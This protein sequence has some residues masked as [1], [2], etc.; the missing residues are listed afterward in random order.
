MF[1]R[2]RVFLLL[3]LPYSSFRL[4]NY[5]I[6]V[7]QWKVP[8]WNHRYINIWLFSIDMQIE[9]S[10]PNL[11]LYL[12]LCTLYVYWVC[13]GGNAW[14]VMP[15]RVLTRG[16]KVPPCPILMVVVDCNTHTRKRK[17]KLEYRN[18][19]VYLYSQVCQSFFN[20]YAGLW[21]LALLLLYVVFSSKS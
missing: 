6:Q 11:Q 3:N 5:L 10:N 18:R 2:F 12:M 15:R 9:E 17:V 8:D 14:S 1:L 16:R 13:L 4:Q 7:W 19:N 20:N 21:T